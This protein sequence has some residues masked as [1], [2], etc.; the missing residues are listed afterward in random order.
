MSTH[1]FARVAAFAAAGILA[2]PAFAYDRELSAEAV[3]EAYFL[4]QRSDE[5]AA[6]FLNRYV[7]RLTWPDRGP[8]ISTVSLFT[9][10]AWIAVQSSR[11]TVG[12]SAQQAEKDYRAHSDVIHVRVRIEFTPTYNAIDDT[13]SKD[14]KRA[15]EGLRIRSQ[16]FWRDFRFELSQDAGPVSPLDVQGEPVYGEGGLR[17][18]EV[19]LTY[20]ARKVASEETA[21]R[22]TMP[23]GQ[24]VTAEFDLSALR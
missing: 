17:G 16:D 18:A 3:R 7:R 1:R 11:K 10:Y 12:Y 21:V 9:P 24:Q 2:A 4:G 6:V 23:G 14:K 20:D 8:Y 22:V 19:W 13:K 15:G 5:S